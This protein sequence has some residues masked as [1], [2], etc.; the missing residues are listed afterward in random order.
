MKKP[1]IKDPR[2]IIVSN[3]ALKKL[4]KISL[5]RPQD[6]RMS[7]T[8]DH[9]LVVYEE[10]LVKPKLNLPER[11]SIP[12]IIDAEKPRTALDLLI[13]QGQKVKRV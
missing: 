5:M 2:H 9:L 10:Q 12:P 4:N 13:E 3:E 11:G 1:A 7:D 8:I 6:V